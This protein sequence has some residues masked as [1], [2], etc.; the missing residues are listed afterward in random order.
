MNDA[1]VIPLIACGI[2]ATVAGLLTATPIGRRIPIRAM[3]W[4]LAIAPAVAFSSLLTSTSVVLEGQA[5]SWSIPWI[6]SLGLRI[7]LLLDG[8]SLL[9]ALLVSGI[10]VLVV[11]Y[12]GYYFSGGHDDAGYAIPDADA[13]R[14][15]H[16]ANTD[17]RFFFYILL[18]M[19]SM[20]GLVMAGDVIALFVFWEGT[21]ITSF[22]LVAY[23]SKDEAARQGA[24]RALFITGG[25]G[26]ALLAGLIFA[27]SIADSVSFSDIL[28]Q[29]DALRASELYPVM[30]GL[31]A[32]GALTKSA[33]APAHFW[34]PGAMSAPA[35][36]SAYLHSATMVK[37]GVYLLARMHPAFGMTD[38]WFWVLSTIG[39]ATMLIGAYVGFK[40]NDLK[41]LLAYSTVSQLGVLVMLIGQDTE[42]AFKALVISILAHALYKSALFLVTGIVDHETGTRDLSKLGGIW[43]VMPA[44]YAVAL[45]ASLSMAG[46]PP[47]FGFLAKET[48]LA[49]ATHPNVPAIVD[50]IFPTA[51]VLAGALILAQAGLIV[52]DA[53]LGK[54]KSELHPHEAPA[55]MW[56]APAIPAVISL[57]IGVLPEPEALA[58]L[59]ARAAAASFGS[60]VKVSL[61][62]W[63]GINIPLVLSVIAVGTG[64]AILASRSRLRPLFTNISGALSLSPLYEGALKAID[65]LA[66]L[67]TRVQNGQLRLYLAIMFISAG[68]MMVTIGRL[69]LPA[70]PSFVVG[71]QPELTTLRFFVLLVIS[72]AALA[73][74]LLRRDLFAIFALAA[75]GLSI[76]VLM[77]LEPAPD[78]ALVQVVVETLTLVVLVLV[79]TRVPR[80]QR[81]RAFEFTFRQ[82]RPG[83]IRD[84]LIALG[85]GAVMFAIVLTALGTRPRESQM[86]PFYEQ[87][88]KPLTS[89]NDIVGAIVIDFRGFDTF[90]EI[91]VFAAAGLAIYTLLRY[92]ARKAGDRDDSVTMSDTSMLPFRGIASPITSPFVRALARLLLPFTLLLAATHVLYGHDQPGD[93]FTAG[94][95]ISLGVAT[96]YVVFGYAETKQRLPWLQPGG[97]IGFGLLLGIGSATAAALINGSFFSPADFGKLLGI[98]SLLPRGVYFS[99]ATL[100]ELAICLTVTGGAVLMMDTLGHPKDSDRETARQM[101]EIAVLRQ[102]GEVTLGE[103]AQEASADLQISPAAPATGSADRTS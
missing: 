73:S 49:T 76:A 42:I 54:P 50:L 43:R 58:T 78:I 29:G 33:Q 77:I 8:L 38:L 21:S 99:T 52:F 90:V 25:G 103:P 62:L 101:D 67:V 22:L 28:R 97:F 6:P 46:L 72:I 95:I 47:L 87:N 3:G 88:A 65:G 2:G 44:T 14:A 45:I 7:S 30:L 57:A 68:A 82:S 102:R 89:A 80:E 41:A 13:P 74:V 94:V 81:E 75:S 17:V 9:F 64:A 4:L 24:F 53:F 86:T 37:A 18:F 5:L 10:G 20:L 16:S 61:A 34:L 85:S 63:T 66:W 96:W 60:P 91:V 26:I 69:S 31:I 71:P 98:G 32:L 100:F 56:L 51:A 27:S 59:L 92:A 11:V 36:A 12:A 23:K 48:L 70:F 1:L 84:V 55:P 40:Q 39:L 35:P 79:L 19:T 93:G 83:L 15:S